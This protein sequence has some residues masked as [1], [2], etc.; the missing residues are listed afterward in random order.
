MFQD[1]MI[2]LYLERLCF[3]T[4]VLLTFYGMGIKRYRLEYLHHTGKVVLFNYCPAHFLRNGYQARL[5]GILSH[6]SEQWALQ[7][8]ISFKPGIWRQYC[9]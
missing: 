9:Q 7:K 6:T 4:I 1:Q 5:D 2:L 3:L 8:S